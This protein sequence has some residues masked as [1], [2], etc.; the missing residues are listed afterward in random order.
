MP[1]S[2]YT[3]LSFVVRKL[4]TGRVIIRGSGYLAGENKFALNS[5]YR[6]GREKME[7]AKLFVGKL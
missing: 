7:E 3:K 2:P 1:P 5:A 6:K 4:V